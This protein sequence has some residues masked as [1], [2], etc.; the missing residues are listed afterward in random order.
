[1]GWKRRVLTGHSAGIALLVTGF[2]VYWG[3]AE[4]VHEGWWWAWYNRVFYLI[5][6]GVFLVMTLLALC[7]VRAGSTRVSRS[8]PH[9]A[10]WRLCLPS[11]Q[12]R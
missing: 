2:W 3:T 7:L 4:M 6:G 1:M 11:P 12:Y 5:P 8:C 10:T 9:H